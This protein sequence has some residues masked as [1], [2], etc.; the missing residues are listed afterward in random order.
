MESFVIKGGKSLNGEVLVSGSKNA[1]LPL[2]FASVATGGVS[3]I[4]CVPDI[5]DVCVALD[6]ISEFGAEI[7][8]ANGTVVIDTRNLHYAEPSEELVGRIRASSYLLGASLARFGKAKIYNFGGCNFESRPIDMHLFAI[9]ELGGEISE[10]RIKVESLVGA[11]IHFDKASVGATINAAIL[12][13]AALGVSRI[14]GYAKEPHVFSLLRFLSASGVRIRRC[15]DFLEIE[16]TPYKSAKCS[17]IPDMIEAAT[18]ISASL[19]TESELLVRGADIK[20]LESFIS[21]MTASGARFSFT[22]KGICTHGKISKPINVVTAPYPDFPTDMQPLT[23]PLMAA[24]S[25]GSIREQVWRGRFGYLEELKKLGL[26]FQRSGESAFISPSSLLPGTADSP[27]LRGGAAL[28]LAA[29]RADG[30]SIVNSAHIIKRG[31]EN[32]VEKLSSLGA[33][34]KERNT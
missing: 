2:I 18:F 26:C 9:R 25:G 7:T 20:H 29:L 27:D 13:S 14:Y 12:A 21:V 16:G 34:I 4:S 3:S 30:E 19:I 5:S 28:I 17:V 15:R 22:D 32:I 6:I 23:A 8:R 11:D 1:A 33:D 31:Y 10:D 24:F